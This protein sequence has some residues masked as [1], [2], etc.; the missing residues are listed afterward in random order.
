MV[1]FRA[2]LAGWASA[3]RRQHSYRRERR[4]SAFRRLRFHPAHPI[5]RHLTARDLHGILVDQL[6]AVAGDEEYQILVHSKVDDIDLHLRAI[7]AIRPVD[8]QRVTAV[9]E[10]TRSVAGVE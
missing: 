4:G 2:A 7:Q 6:P 8:S 10:L 5:G 9:E 1:K 3:R